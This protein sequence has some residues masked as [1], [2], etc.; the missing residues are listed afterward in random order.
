MSATVPIRYVGPCSHI[1]IP[2]VGVEGIERG[3]TVEAGPSLAGQPP[4]PWQPHQGAPADDGRQYRPTADGW[5]VRDPGSGLLAQEDT[6]QPVTSKRAASPAA[7]GKE[8]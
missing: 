3:A 4:G 5:E 8:G 7:D 6:W 1:S 2:S